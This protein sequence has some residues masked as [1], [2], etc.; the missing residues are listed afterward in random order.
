MLNYIFLKVIVWC[1]KYYYDEVLPRI[2]I[3]TVKMGLETELFYGHE[4]GWQDFGLDMEEISYRESGVFVGRFSD[5]AIDSAQTKVDQKKM[6]EIVEKKS[7]KKH[8]KIVEKF[9]GEGS[10]GY[11]VKEWKVYKGHG[12]ER[13]NNRFRDIVHQ[14][15]K[16][17]LLP[18]KI[19]SKLKAGP[20][21]AAQGYGIK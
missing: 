20:R 6:K 21:L 4:H 8:E 10:K 13:V 3:S 7:K 2:D 17:H 15:D 16:P 19:R 14:S 12:S 9:I 18:E 1:K 11:F 5:R